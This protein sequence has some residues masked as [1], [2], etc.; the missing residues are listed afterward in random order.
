MTP[1]RAA[2]SSALSIISRGVTHTGQPRPVNQLNWLRQQFINAE[3]DD[4]VRLPAADLHYF[5]W[6][7]RGPM[8]LA[9]KLLREPGIAVFVQ[10]FHSGTGVS[11]VN[12]CVLAVSETHGRDARATT[13]SISWR[14]LLQLAQLFDLF[15]ILENFLR[16]VFI[17]PA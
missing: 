17:H 16:L 1:G 13:G 11:P 2:I 5:P 15:Q 4:G 7:R 9:R 6:S 8:K 3:L 10:K 12:I 14:C